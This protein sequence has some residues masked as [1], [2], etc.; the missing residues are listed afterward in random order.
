MSQ[1]VRIA[2]R[3]SPLALWQA[4]FVKTEL[5]KYHS[6]IAVELVPMSTQ[7][8]KIL[9]TPLAKIGGKGLF[10]KELEMAMLEG[11]A[12]IAVH[13]MKDVPMEFPE[14]LGLS[15]ICEREDP[16]DAFVSNTYQSIDELPQGASVGTCSLRRQCQLQAK[17]PDIKILELRGNV[18]TRLSKLDAGN[19]DGI[20]LAT[21]GLERLKMK[22][23][24][25]Q[26]INP[27]WMLPAGGQGAV[28]IETRSDDEEI[29]LLLAPLN[30]KETSLRVL[31]ERAVNN[32]LQGGCQ[33]PI[34]VYATLNS[35]QNKERKNGEQQIKIEALVGRIDGSLIL[36]DSIEGHASD[37][38]K[39]GIELATR[40][41]D[42][43]A[44]EILS[45]LYD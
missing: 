35:F 7:G 43:G 39:L 3:K 21:A 15:I 44:I 22:E 33:V 25:S 8:D 14:G 29:K 4:E 31:A 26:K 9:D 28:G 10:V 30:H 16:R 40:L 23:R 38:E 18:Q 27:D 45:A 34:G 1:I 42:A 41:L 32:H 37:G 11:R 12:D 13:S 24:I 2:T 19:Y 17:R 20:I 36:R 5:E 6:D